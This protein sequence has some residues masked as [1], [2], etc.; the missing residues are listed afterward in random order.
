MVFYTNFP[1]LFYFPD[2][3]EILSFCTI[4]FAMVIF[5]WP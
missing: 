4:A 1:G 3:A 2:E 5:V